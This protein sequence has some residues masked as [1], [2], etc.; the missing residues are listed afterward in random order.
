MT[1]RKQTTTQAGPTRQSVV[2]PQGE[3]LPLF[4]GQAPTAVE[5]PFQPQEDPQSAQPHRPAS[6]AQGRG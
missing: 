5:R 3:D 4:T 1:T 6:Y 2:G